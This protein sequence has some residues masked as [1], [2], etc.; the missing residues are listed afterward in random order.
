VGYFMNA[1]EIGLDQAKAAYIAEISERTGQRIEAGNHQP[2][3]GKVAQRVPAQD[4]LPTPEFRERWDELTAQFD[5]DT[6]AVLV[7]EALYIAAPQ[8][9]EAAV[10][11]EDIGV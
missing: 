6:A 7:V 9:Q 1:R 5:L 8:D 3:R 4:L 10:C 2:N 11:L